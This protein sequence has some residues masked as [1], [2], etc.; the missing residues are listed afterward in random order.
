MLWCISFDSEELQIQK[1]TNALKIILCFS[2]INKSFSEKRAKIKLLTQKGKI[3]ETKHDKIHLK[4]KFNFSSFLSWTAAARWQQTNKIYLLFS[5]VH[6]QVTNKN[7]SIS[8]FL[9]ENLNLE[10]LV[11]IFFSINVEVSNMF[12]IIWAWTY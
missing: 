11:E 4:S 3:D 1:K 5:T 2:T 6:F 12:T 7:I 10:F 8:H 9:M